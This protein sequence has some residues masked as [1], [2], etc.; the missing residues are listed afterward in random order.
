MGQS[1]N[2][3]Y[4]SLKLPEMAKTLNGTIFVF[5]TPYTEVLQ[6][7]KVPEDGDETQSEEF[8]YI[9]RIGNFTKTYF[10]EETKSIKIVGLG[11][12]L[13]FAHELATMMYLTLFIQS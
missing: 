5:S 1:F 11:D 9:E 3:F 7:Q 6:I 2:Y 8:R 4:D 12:M 10:T 13:F